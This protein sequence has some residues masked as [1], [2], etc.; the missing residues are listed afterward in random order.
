MAKIHEE[1]IVIKIST[2]LPD[3]AD[4]TAIMDNDNIQALEQVIKEFAGDNRTLV[5]IERA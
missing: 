4:M 1:I 3:A 5:E 2:L